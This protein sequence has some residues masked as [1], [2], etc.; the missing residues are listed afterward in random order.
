M[1]T[2]SINRALSLISKSSDQI[3]SLIRNGIFVSTVQGSA[4]RPTDKTFK[5]KEELQKRIQSDTDKVNSYLEL[6]VDLK[7][8]I[9]QKN[10]ET[11]VSFDSRQI[12]VTELLAIK[13]QLTHRRLLLAKLRS[14]A[15][16]ANTKVEDN[17]RQI[18]T[19]MEKT[20]GSLQ[21]RQALESLNAISIISYNDTS[22]ATTIQTLQEQNEYLEKEVDFALSEI[23]IATFITVDNVNLSSV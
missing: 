4:N 23:N 8:A 22:V 9:A 15:Q 21:D 16:D 19:N 2:I 17:Q 5:T 12:S 10:L 20:N 14:Q 3:N 18:Q 11:F 1:A 7:T 6:I 13:Q